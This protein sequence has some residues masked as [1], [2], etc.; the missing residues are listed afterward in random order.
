MEAIIAGIISG[1]FS[2]L[3]IWLQHHLTENKK[4]QGNN[5]VASGI[6]EVIN[7]VEFEKPNIK[8]TKNS[9]EQALQEKSYAPNYFLIGVNAY[10]SP[11][12]VL[13]IIFGMNIAVFGA[14]IGWVIV[15]VILTIV[16]VGKNIKVILLYF[17]L[18]VAYSFGIFALF[19]GVIEEIW[20]SS[21]WNIYIPLGGTIIGMLWALAIKNHLLKN[22]R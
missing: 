1:L 16:F 8:E 9:A 19:E 21:S 12:L 14:T 11:G 6:N 20:R 2:L 3:A 10:L 13:L 5:D 15:S 18:S 7:T 4:N 22:E 17:L